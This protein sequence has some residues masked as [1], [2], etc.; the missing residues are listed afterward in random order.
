MDAR[1]PWVGSWKGPEAVVPAAGDGEGPRPAAVEPLA[2]VGP[3]D[4][5]AP[6][7]RA[8]GRFVGEVRADLGARCGRGPALRWRGGL[9]GRTAGG[10]CGPGQQPGQDGKDEPC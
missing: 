9:R 4:E 5:R 10:W 8:A 7:V 6:A 1:G 3:D 2:L